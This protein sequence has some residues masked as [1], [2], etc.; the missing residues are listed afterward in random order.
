MINEKRKENIVNTYKPKIVGINILNEAITK[1]YNLT[2]SSLDNIENIITT[3]ENELKT[4]GEKPSDVIKKLKDSFDAVKTN[5]NENKNNLKSFYTDSNKSINSMKKEF[6]LSKGKTKPIINQKINNNPY[7]KQISDTPHLDN[8]FSKKANYT[9]INITNNNNN[10]NNKT[11]K[12]NTAIKKRNNTINIPINNPV[13]NTINNAKNNEMN[14]TMNIT[15]DNKINTIC[16]TH[17][18]SIKYITEINKMS[19]DLNIKK[20]E[21]ENLKKELESKDKEIE[22]L[23]S[24]LSNQ[25]AKEKKALVDSIISIFE[26]DSSSKSSSSDKP[27]N[28]LSE[29]VNRI[30]D[31]YKL[32][33]ETLKKDK[34]IFQE[35]ICHLQ[36]ELIKHIQTNLEIKN[37]YNKIISEIKNKSKELEFLYDKKN[38]ENEQLKCEIATKEMKILNLQIEIE[39]IKSSNDILIDKNESNLKTKIIE[40]NKKIEEQN[41]IIREI[42]DKYINATIENGKLQ[43]YKENQFRPANI[44]EELIRENNDLKNENEDLKVKIN[45][46]KFMLN[47]N[48]N[49]GGNEDSSLITKDDEEEKSFKSKYENLQRKYND[50]EY[51]YNKLMMNGTNKYNGSGNHDENATIKELQKDNERLKLLNSSLVN[52]LEGLK[53]S[54]IYNKTEDEKISVYDEEFDLQKMAKGAKAKNV[55]QDLNIDNPGLQNIKEKYRELDY[56]YKT[57]E[58]NISKILKTVQENEENKKYIDEIRKIIKF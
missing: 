32:E 5:I 50:L 23:K 40:L 48:G 11:R 2:N 16:N 34:G 37:E 39:N 33:N 43:K 26:K 41:N 47:S 20:E 25:G 31:N 53:R 44:S 42:N 35:K 52:R 6:I 27:W 10:N 14:S 24:N 49:I 1:Y 45:N 30:L 38:E 21:I 12:S 57:L 46:L 13:K 8:P 54:N 9:K 18:K 15:T 19:L 55:S 7:K 3:F 56:F 58:Y 51:N 22:S 4:S 29:S 36:N 28:T 17:N